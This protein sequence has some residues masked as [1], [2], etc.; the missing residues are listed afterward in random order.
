MSPSSDRC[1]ADERA[2]VVAAHAE[3]GLRQ[4]VGAEAEEL[5]ILG[6]LIG[7]HAGAR[8]FDHRADQV[9][10]LRALLGE[11][12]VGRLADDLLLVVELRQEADQRNHHFGHARR[13]LPSSRRRP[14][15]RSPGPASR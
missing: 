1:K 4:V 13:C 3:R 14:L 7:D 15:R 8:H 9:L 10:D 12:L 11:D 2:V 6:D 5:G